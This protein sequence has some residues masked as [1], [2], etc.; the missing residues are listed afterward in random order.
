MELINSLHC[1]QEHAT[2]P[3][4]ETDDSTPHPPTV[5]LK[6]IF[7]IILPYMRRAFVVKRNSVV[8]I[9]NKCDSYQLVLYTTQMLCYLEFDINGC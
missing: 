9:N 2:V 8:I 7:N 5:S 6:F 4:P 1:S 3:Y